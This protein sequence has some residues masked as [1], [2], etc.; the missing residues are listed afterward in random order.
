ML[1][2]NTFLK[3]YKSTKTTSLKFADPKLFFPPAQQLTMLT[4]TVPERTFTQQPALPSAPLQLMTLI[5]LARISNFIALTL[6]CTGSED[7]GS[8][9]FGSASRPQQSP[10]AP[11]HSASPTFGL[12]SMSGSRA[13]RGGM[14][15]SSGGGVE[16]APEVFL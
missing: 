14:L 9:S 1:T 16:S 3:L 2:G 5:W 10:G 6:V 7:S 13:F 12:K 11:Y 8:C 15:A 4:T